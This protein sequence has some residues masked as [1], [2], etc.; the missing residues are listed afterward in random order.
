[1][2]L[3][4]PA[5]ALAFAL[6]WGGS[7]FFLTWWMIAAGGADP[8]PT[9]AGQIYFGYTVTPLGSLVG[10]AW[11]FADGLVGGAL[12]ALLYNWLATKLARGAPGAAAERQPS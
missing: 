1:M 7:V 12:L 4:V 3:N 5:F 8:G 11:G 2:K 9:L 10:L 6:W